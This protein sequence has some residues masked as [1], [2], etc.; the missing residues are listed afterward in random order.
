MQT[1][2]KVIMPTPFPARKAQPQVMPL[3]NPPEGKTYPF[4]KAMVWK[5]IRDHCLECVGSAEAIRS[6][7]GN[8]L[9]ANGGTCRLYP[10]RFGPKSVKSAEEFGL[11][12]ADY[13]QAKL[14]EAIRAECKYCLN[15]YPLNIC[16]SPNCKLFH[17]RH[18]RSSVNYSKPL[19]EEQ[20]ARLNALEERRRSSQ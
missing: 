3:S 7:G 17:V 18:R 9:L 14:Y 13:S 1:L 12:K 4:P 11:T 10:Y 19:T 8:E 15:G 16:S 2:P 5:A 6:C 20:R